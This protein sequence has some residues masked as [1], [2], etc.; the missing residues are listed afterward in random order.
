MHYRLYHPDDFARLYSIEEICFQPPIRFS[1]PYLRGIIE[2]SSSITW[3]AEENGR[4]VGFSVVNCSDED[5]GV[6]AYIQTIEVTPEYRRHGI[7]LELL[8]RM[9][10]SA[11]ERGASVIWL[12]VDTTNEAA[13][14]LYKAHGFR[15]QGRQAHYYAR[16][17]AADVY[18]KSLQPAD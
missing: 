10:S 11:R 6:M 15:H 5:I 13:I 1:R 4:E 7:G 16:G 14:G 8:R 12:H 2:R 9:E 17:R 3:V 18:M